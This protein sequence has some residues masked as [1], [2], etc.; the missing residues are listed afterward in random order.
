LV[1]KVS[2]VLPLDDYQ[3]INHQ[4]HYPGWLAPES[5][6]LGLLPST[7]GLFNFGLVLA[8]YVDHGVY[9]EPQQTQLESLGRVEALGSPTYMLVV[10]M[11][12]DT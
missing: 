4:I 6:Y 1:W 8:V 3:T 5:Y 2:W 7:D 11:R 12:I 9:T 10:S